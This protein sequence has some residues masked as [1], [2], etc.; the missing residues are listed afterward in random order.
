MLRGD[1]CCCSCCRQDLRSALGLD[2]RSLWNTNTKSQV[3]TAT[4][5]DGLPSRPSCPRV[6]PVVSS[7]SCSS[8]PHSRCSVL[9]RVIELYR[10]SSPIVYSLS[11]KNVIQRFVQVICIRSNRL[12]PLSYFFLFMLVFCMSCVWQLLNKRIY[13]DDNLIPTLSIYIFLSP[14]FLSILLP[15]PPFFTFVYFSFFSFFRFF[16][17]FPG[18]CILYIDAFRWDFLKAVLC[19]IFRITLSRKTLCSSLFFRV[20]LYSWPAPSHCYILAECFVVLRSTVNEYKDYYYLYLYV[21]LQSTWQTAFCGNS[22][23]C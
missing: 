13:D 11:N 10:L 5:R 9:Q 22:R 6:R 18:F 20:Q 8:S 15:L 16:S 3:V 4:W 1:C 17:Y 21:W 14:T 7:R 23:T 2:V 12:P 19:C